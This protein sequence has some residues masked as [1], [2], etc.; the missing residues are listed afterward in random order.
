MKLIFCPACWDMVKMSD[1]EKRTCECGASWG[2]YHEDGLHATYGGLCVPIGIA[3]DSFMLALT[4]D[5]ILE[6]QNERNEL[7]LGIRFEAF[8]IPSI[9]PTIH[10]ELPKPEHN[11]GAMGYNPMLGDQCQACLNESKSRNNE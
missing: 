10:K 5:K 6:E 9:A 2:Y 4:K 11:C 7:S 3:N 1:E 8:V